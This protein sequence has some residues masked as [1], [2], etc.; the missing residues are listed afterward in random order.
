MALQQT[1]REAGASGR[2]S[3]QWIVI[4]LDGHQHGQTPNQ[5]AE[6]SESLGIP[7]L[8]YDNEEVLSPGY[9][10]MLLQDVREKAELAAAWRKDKRRRAL[11]ERRKREREA[12]A[13]RSSA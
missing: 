11:K 9:F 6:R 5:D 12:A 4:E 1:C 8:R 10:S 13:R 3:C 2:P 7:V